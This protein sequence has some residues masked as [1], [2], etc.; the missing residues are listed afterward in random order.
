MKIKNIITVFSMASLLLILS[1]FCFFGKHDEYSESERRALAKFP[2]VTY[3]TVTSGEFAKDFEEYATDAFPMR[4]SFRSLKAYTRLYVFLQSD[5]NGIYVKDNYL[6]KIDYPQNSE[7]QNYA[8]DLFQKIY[9]RHLAEN[10]VYFAMIPDKNIF[11]ADLSMDYDKLEK[12]MAEKMPYATTIEIKDLLSK[13]DYYYTD[14]HWKQES[15]VAVADML[16][17]EMGAEISGKY[18]EVKVEEPFFGVYVGQSALRVEPDSLTYLTNETIENYNVTI[19]DGIKETDLNSA[20]DMSKVTSK[21]PY[22]MYLSGNQPL[23]TIDNP[24][25]GND[26]RLIIF[27]DSFGSSVAPI[28][29][30]GY[31][32]TVLVDLR[33]LNSDFLPMLVDFEGADVLFLYSSLILNSSMSMK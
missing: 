22:E 18:R 1:L 11:L 28:L 9:D 2:E 5:N 27:R 14:T 4:D 12:D 23:V 20:Y 24:N 10:E 30:E 15:I 29:A 16:C 19:F 25:A 32:E 21:D 17:G 8:A 26:K 13:N 33:Y 31:R 6:S 3:K 7:M